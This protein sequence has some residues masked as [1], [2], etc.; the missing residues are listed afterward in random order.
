MY[1][2]SEIPSYMKCFL[3]NPPYGRAERHVRLSPLTFAENVRTPT[4]ILHGESDPRVP[5]SQSYEFYQALREVGAATTLVAYPRESHAFEE[6]A[7]QADL[8][9]RVLE[10]YQRHLNK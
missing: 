6:R 9:R 1:G 10:W 4:L 3:P 7:H 5:I 2:T 8:L